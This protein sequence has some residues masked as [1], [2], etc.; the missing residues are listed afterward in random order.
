MRHHRLARPGRGL[1]LTLLALAGL[2]LATSPLALAA[3]NFITVET[4]AWNS[5]VDG[6]CSLEEAIATGFVLADDR[7]ALLAEAEA[8]EFG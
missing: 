2:T 3:D 8:V 6:L 5:T 1:G 4:L 7:A